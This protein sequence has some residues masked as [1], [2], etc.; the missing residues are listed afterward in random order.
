MSGNLF[1]ERLATF[2]RNPHLIGVLMVPK[3][4]WRVRGLFITLLIILGITFFTPFVKYLYY[5]FFVVV[6][7]CMAVI[8]AYGADEVLLVTSKTTD[9]ISRLWRRMLVVC[10]M[11]AIGVCLIQVVVHVTGDKLI[12]AAQRYV[13]KASVGRVYS[14]HPEWFQ[15]RVL[16]FFQHYRLSN[17]LFWLPLTGV[18]AAAMAWMALRRTR[19]SRIG[20]A[21]VLIG[22]TVADLVVLGWQ[23]VPQVSLRR[24]PLYPPLQVVSALQADPDL[25]RVQTWPTEEGMLLPDNI[26]QVYGLSSTTGNDSL[27]PAN[28]KLLP[29]NVTDHAQLLDLMNVKY[30]IT[31]ATFTLPAERFDL[32]LE[33]QGCRLYRNPRCLSRIQ[34][35]PR[36]EVVSD[37]SNILQRVTA[38]T[39][40]P[41]QLVFVN[42]SP[43]AGFGVSGTSTETSAVP[44]EIN[45]RHYG[46]QRV[47]V[48]I[49]TVVPGVLL[50]A[51]T[52][53]PGWQAQLD[54][55]SVPICRG[56][57]VMRA[58]FVPKGQHRIVF[59]YKSPVFRYGLAI[60]GITLVFAGVIAIWN[61]RHRNG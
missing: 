12:I 3:R 16:L 50:L 34:F 10:A 27:A 23:I 43:P 41:R 40:N 4:D 21:V 37:P 31:M 19:L 38:P 52:W 20:F 36:W 9:Q 28:L 46:A 29:W 35:L 39:F 2:L 42:Q 61:L 18:F 1:P 11:V 6:A 8:A 5:R 57:Y 26:L 22:F 55:H 60:S 30:L 59:V 45:I 53:Y 47:I 24:Y 44:A 51:D 13:A 32:I 54:H 48:D 14:D 7:F 33:A 25:F 56:D 49:N 15:K 17:V 58:V